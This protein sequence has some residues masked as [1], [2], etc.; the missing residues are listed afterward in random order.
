MTRRLLLPLLLATAA[1]ADEGQP[2]TGHWKGWLEVPGAKLEIAVTLEEAAGKIDIPAQGA[3]GLALDQV[4]LEAAAA[5][6]RIAGVPGEPTFRGTLGADGALAGEMTQGPAKVPFRLERAPEGPKGRPQ[7]PKPPFPYATQEVTV[8]SGDVTLA[9]TLTLPPG[10][11]PFPAALLIT[12]SG[13]QDR[14]EALMGHRPFLVLADA[15]ARAGIATLRLDD[16][17][18]GKSGGGD[19]QPTTAD[20][21]RDALAAVAFLRAQ[22]RVA[23]DAVGLIGHSEGGVV[24]PLAATTGE[25]VAF[26][27]MLAGTGVPGDQ[28]LPAQ[29]AAMSLAA[30]V[31]E[32]GVARQRAA[33]EAALALLRRDAPEG[34]VR[35]AVEAFVRVQ[36]GLALPG[37]EPAPAQVKQVVDAQLQMFAV[38]WWR[39]FLRHD[40][41]EALRALSK[42]PVLVLNG[43]LD[44]QVLPD[45]NLPAIEAALRAAG[46]P[47]VTIE[48]LPGLNHLFQTAKTGSPAEYALIDETIAPA[49]LERISGWILERFGRR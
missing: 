41:A 24:A 43:E 28:I 42:P 2:L 14:D 30:G 9:G 49:V 38:P 29:L 23:E 27:V 20:F 7:D 5:T 44:L 39:F 31:P 35:A 34:E 3:F 6:F 4:E 36:L 26:V 12:G 15:L 32:E 11:G 48:R 47:D 21:A 33:Q 1:L 40:P 19:T 8:R 46:N 13:P 17:G 25:G 18:V 37:Q 10:E 45:Q 22:P 16:R